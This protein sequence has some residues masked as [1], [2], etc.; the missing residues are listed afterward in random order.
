[1]FQEERWNPAWLRV[2]ELLSLLML[3]SCGFFL[4]GAAIVSCFFTTFEAELKG[5][6]TFK[7]FPRDG[8]PALSWFVSVIVHQ[9]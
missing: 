5:L 3:P 9:C 8:E 4:G 2:V 1:M 7:F 6:T